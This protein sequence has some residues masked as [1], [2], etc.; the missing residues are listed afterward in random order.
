MLVNL[1]HGKSQSIDKS[2]LTNEDYVLQWWMARRV[3]HQTRLNDTL[4]RKNVLCLKF[5]KKIYGCVMTSENYIWYIHMNL[6]CCLYYWSYF[7][8]QQYFSVK[9]SKVSSYTNLHA[10]FISPIK[11]IY[12]PVAIKYSVSTHFAWL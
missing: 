2:L 12:K 5:D 1:N 4:K 11:T 9:M 10:T 6:I 8:L 7:I 3:S